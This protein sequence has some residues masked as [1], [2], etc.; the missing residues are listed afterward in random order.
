[1]CSLFFSSIII[2]DQSN[3][4]KM[5]SLILISWGFIWEYSIFEWWAVEVIG[6]HM[7]LI[8]RFE[9]LFT[10]CIELDGRKKRRRHQNNRLNIELFGIWGGRERERVNFQYIT[11]RSIPT[12]NTR[13]H[14]LSELSVPIAKDD[15]ISSGLQQSKLFSN[16]LVCTFPYVWAHLFRSLTLPQ[17]YVWAHV[18]VCVCVNVIV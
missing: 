15:W 7:Q 5:L 12:Y 9:F 18:C 17:L 8:E 14:Q 6:T 13:N 16:T 3:F 1:M 4:C 10:L 11:R 2:N